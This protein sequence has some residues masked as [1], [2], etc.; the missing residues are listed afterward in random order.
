ML[1]QDIKIWLG[2]IPIINQSDKLGMT[3]EL[4]DITFRGI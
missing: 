4:L 2:G 3:S 1:K